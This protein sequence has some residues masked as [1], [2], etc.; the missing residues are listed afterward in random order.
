MGGESNI[1]MSLEEKKG[2]Q[3]RLEEECEVFKDTIEDLVLVNIIPGEGWF[4]WKNKREGENHI[5]SN[6]DRFLVLELVTN[7]GSETHSATL[8]GASSDHSPIEL[9]WSGLGSQFKNSFR[10]EKF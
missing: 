8:L 6:I 1:I 7:S 5:A 3:R 9:M 10:P 2:G 4:T